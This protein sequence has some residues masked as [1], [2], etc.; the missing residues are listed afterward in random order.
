MREGC[1]FRKPRSAAGVLQE[2]QVIGAQS[3]W[4]QGK[5]RTFCKG[6]RECD[7]VRQ[8]SVQRR[9]GERRGG[10]VAEANADHLLDRGLA[11]DLSKTRGYAAEDD[12]DLD[13]SVVQLV[14]ELARRIERIDVHLGRARA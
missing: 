3:Y 1:A 8:S 7:R 5:S 13:A 10:T 14:F 6:V 11:D 2:Q 9:A 4:R 12:D